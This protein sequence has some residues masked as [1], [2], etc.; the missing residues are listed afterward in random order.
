MDGGQL[1]GNKLAVTF[2]L[3]NKGMQ[4]IFNISE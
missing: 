1:D 3:L 2:V 4:T